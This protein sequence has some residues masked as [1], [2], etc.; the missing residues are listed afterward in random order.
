MRTVT[1]DAYVPWGQDR[2]VCTRLIYRG[3]A[4]KQEIVPNS[5]Q[6]LSAARKNLLDWAH[7]EGFTHVKDIRT[8]LTEKIHRVPKGYTAEELDRD[9]PFNQLTPD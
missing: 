5:C 3:V 1:Y 8:G 2:W 9:N 6:D 7:R 4:L